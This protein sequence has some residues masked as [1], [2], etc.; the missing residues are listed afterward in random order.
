ML[1]HYTH[2]WVGDDSTWNRAQ[3]WAMVGYALMYLWTRERECLDV[4]TCTVDLR[5][6]Y[7]CRPMANWARMATS[8]LPRITRPC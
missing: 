5:L 8:G 3:A 1:R 7:T 4:A 6:V 2:K